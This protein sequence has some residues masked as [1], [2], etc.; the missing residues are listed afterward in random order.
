M[1]TVTFASVSIFRLS[2]RRPLTVMALFGLLVLGLGV[3][4]RS[5]SSALSASPVR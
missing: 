3:A 1:S 2:P 5:T 4:M